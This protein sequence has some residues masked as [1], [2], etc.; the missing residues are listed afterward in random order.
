VRRARPRSLILGIT[1]S[2]PMLFGSLAEKSCRRRAAPTAGSPQDESVRLADWQPA[3]P[4]SFSAQSI[5]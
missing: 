4:R 1:G 5:L 2:L 3:L